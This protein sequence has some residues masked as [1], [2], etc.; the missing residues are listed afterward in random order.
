[1]RYSILM[2]GDPKTVTQSITNDAGVTADVHMA[3]VE[4]PANAYFVGYFD[5]GPGQTFDLAKAR[6][7]AVQKVNGTLIS[8]RKITLGDNPGLE[9]KASAKTGEQT[10]LVVARFYRVGQRVYMLQF[11]VAAPPSNDIPDSA[12]RFFDSF[13]LTQ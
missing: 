4:T 11:L 7:G 6:D 1:G 9:F 12:L 13:Q 10:A 3:Y 8:E 5:L 2:P